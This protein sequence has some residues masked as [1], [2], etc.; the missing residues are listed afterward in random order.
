M[1]SARSRFLVLAMHALFYFEAI[2]DGAAHPIMALVVEAYKPYRRRWRCLEL[3]TIELAQITQSCPESLNHHLRCAA[4]VS[5]VAAHTHH[6]SIHHSIAALVCSQL[7][8]ILRMSS[9]SCPIPPFREC[10]LRDTTQ[11]GNPEPMT[12]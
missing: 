3:I 2:V 4:V 11:S 7:R 10:H 1:I 8:T 5:L 9:P 6:Q 12:C